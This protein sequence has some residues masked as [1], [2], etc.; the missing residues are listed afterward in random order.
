MI[1]IDPICLVD[2]DSRTI[3]LGKQL[4]ASGPSLGPQE[5]IMPIRSI[6]LAA[7]FTL[8]SLGAAQADGVRP[9]QAHSIDLGEVSGVAYYTV[10]PDGFRVVTT[11]A[12][13]EAGT[14]VRVVA[15]LAPGQS[16]VLSTGVASTIEISRQAD[17]VLIRDAAAATN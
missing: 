16:V 11:L 7:A 4:R 15:V 5:I 10:E 3:S 14:P 6:F 13:G 17:T 9:I 2:N 1:I 12:Q 8:T